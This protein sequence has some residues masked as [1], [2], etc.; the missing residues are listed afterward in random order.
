V[1]DRFESP[2][3]RVSTRRKSSDVVRGMMPLSAPS[4][5]VN[6]HT[7]GRPKACLQPIIESA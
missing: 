5:V 6:H 4:T 7:L 3:M 1:Y 2:D